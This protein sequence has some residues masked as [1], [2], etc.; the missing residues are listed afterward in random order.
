MTW[1]TKVVAVLLLALWV[2]VTMHCELQA[3]VHSVL[4]QCCCGDEATQG[5]A[6]ADDVCGTVESGFYKVEENEILTAPVLAFVALAPDTLASLTSE[7]ALEPA[8]PEPGPPQELPQSWQF[9]YRVALP[10]RAPSLA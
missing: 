9:S 3:A 4:L 1:F 7:P 8:I 6:H 10:P 5:P 2:P